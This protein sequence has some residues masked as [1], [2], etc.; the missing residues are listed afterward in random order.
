LTPERLETYVRVQGEILTA[1]ARLVAPGGR[2]VYAT[3]S[4]LP[5]EN[6][7][8]VARF[9]AAHPDFAPLPLAGVWADTVGGACPAAGGE[10]LLT[11]ARHGTD[12]FYLAV[13]ER[14][15]GP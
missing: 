3:C 5:E 9:R 2:L 8:Q 6:G 15:A 13:L 1:A 14:R 12:G 7:R 10:L 4:L 11:P